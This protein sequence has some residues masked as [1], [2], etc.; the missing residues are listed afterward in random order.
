MEVLHE[1]DDSDGSDKEHTEENEFYSDE[2]L[3]EIM[4]RTDVEFELF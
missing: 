1:G 2:Q 4:A 3:N